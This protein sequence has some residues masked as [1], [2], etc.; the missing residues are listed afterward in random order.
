MTSDE[1]RLTV[2]YGT[3]S[4]TLEGYD[5][6]VE[7]MKTIVSFFREIAAQDSGFGTTP[8]QHDPETLVRMAL[9]GHRRDA[10]DA[11]DGVWLPEEDAPM[12]AATVP[13][14]TVPAAA[15]PDEA[16]TER[17]A[18]FFASG[19]PAPPAGDAELTS[20]TTSAVALSAAARLK[21][22]RGDHPD[23]A[24]ASGQAPVPEE[25]LRA[26]VLTVDHDD[27]DALR[28]A[29]DDASDPGNDVDRL[30][31]R[32]AEAMSEP[33]GSSRRS[34]YA[35]LRAA[36]A[37]RGADDTLDRTDESAAHVESYRMDLDRLITSGGEKETPARALPVL[38]LVA[39]QRVDLTEE[40][41]AAPHGFVAYA[42]RLGATRVPDVLEAAAAYLSFVEGRSP[43]SREDVLR[44]ASAARDVDS[45]EACDAFADLVQ[46]G[47]IEA[48]NGGSFRATVTNTFGPDRRAAG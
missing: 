14:D 36:V 48:C 2:S 33:A 10:A 9:S 24:T 44:C 16:A 13:T 12:T 5:D 25:P 8:I 1:K 35:H 47:R 40:A 45:A 19:T 28:R 3:F 6:P 41:A 7:T 32:A 15:L 18:A 29:A 42:A 37:A 46:Q 38:R 21:A 30:M 34:D 17:V 43:F 31:D 20:T 39:E 22:L 23:P 26:R 4:C 27:L 11:Q